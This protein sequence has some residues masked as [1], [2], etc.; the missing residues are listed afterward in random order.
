MGR[1]TRGTTQGIQG[2]AQGRGDHTMASLLLPLLVLSSFLPALGAGCKGKAVQDCHMVRNAA[3]CANVYVPLLQDKG[4][5]WQCMWYTA[6]PPASCVMGSRCAV[7]PAPPTPTPPPTP[8]PPT[9]P[10][11]PSPPTPPPTPKPPTPT[12]KPPAPPT[13]K[14]PTPPPAPPSPTPTPPPS[15]PKCE[16][17]SAGSV[18]C[19]PTAMPAQ[20]C[21][22]NIPCCDCGTKACKCSSASYE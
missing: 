14:P 5:G 1:G 2:T 17:C 20:Y 11:T 19:D 16:V 7:V 8:I 10:P 12:P 21:P 4:V 22:G 9:P 6:F 18:C 3:E 15:P 13:P